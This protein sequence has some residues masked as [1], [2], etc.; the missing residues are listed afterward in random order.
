MKKDRHYYNNGIEQRLYFDYEDIPDGFI[1][2]GLSK[3]KGKP[4][5]N[6]DKISITD[7]INNKYIDI[8]DLDMWVSN[9]WY[10]GFIYSEEGKINHK[11]S[12]IET[13]SNKSY[14]QWIDDHNKRSLGAKK[15]WKNRTSEEIE[16]YTRNG[17][18]KLLDNEL[19]KRRGPTS[20]NE[21]I[22]YD[23][24]CK[25]YGEEDVE[26]SYYDKYRYPW[27]CDFYIKSKDI[28]IELNIFPSH[29]KEPFDKNN[30]DHLKL[31]EKIKY[32][33]SNWVE[34]TMVNVW[35]GSDIMKIDTAKKNKL[36][37]FT[38]YNMEEFYRWI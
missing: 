15:M 5:P 11:K 35:A 1:R 17:L 16:Q 28:F 4:A 13:R 2:G 22:V 38:F 9:G 27:H 30:K 26:W 23:L 18:E 36:K 7:G 29:Y 32:S 25:K 12:V 20:E 3:N 21:K 19:Y 24:L 6:K 8:N 33:P 10:E 31:L 34:E 14:D 37:Y